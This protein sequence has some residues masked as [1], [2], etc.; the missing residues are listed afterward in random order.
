MKIDIKKLKGMDLFYYLTSSE[1]TDE[2]L[3][4]MA[5]LLVGY[6]TNREEALKTLEEVAM[7]R[8]RL[9]AIYPG[10]G[11]V[12]TKNMKLVCGIPDGG[13]YIE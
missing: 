8:K 11:D 1:N 3:S 6:S 10:L 5:S 13:L 12:P 9:I 7:G 2:E 4:E